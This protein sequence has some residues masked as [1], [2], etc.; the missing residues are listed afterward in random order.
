M[1][2]LRHVLGMAALFVTAFRFSGDAAGRFDQKLIIDKQIVHVLNRLTFGPRPGDVEQVRRMGVDKWI[3][4][5]LHPERITENPGLEAKVKP[6]ETTQLAMW[7]IMD[8]YAQPPAGF[9]VVPPSQKALNSLPQQQL[10]RLRNGSTEERV[11]TLALLDPDTRRLVLAAAGPPILEGLP[12]AVQ[13]EATK[14][15]QDEQAELQKERLRLMPPLNE[16]L[17]QDQVRTARQG[18]K[19][20]KAALLNSFDADKRQKVLRALGP[21]PFSDM[22]DL[23]REVMAA[24]QPQQLVNSELIE[25][26][27][28]R[29]VYSNRQLE[30]VLVDFWLNHFNVFNGKGQDRLYLTSF[31][32]DAIRPYVF[33]HFKDMLLATA[34]HPAML[35]YLDN[36]QSQ[37]MRDDQ[38]FQLPPG[39]QRP[40]LNENY[41]RELM[42]LHTLGV[43]GGYTQQD[44]IA[45]ARA[46]S[47]WS[48]YDIGKY[49]EF[50]F[51]PGSHD[52]KEKVVLGHTLPAGRGE[53]DGI[54]VIDILAHHPSTA[55]FISKELAQRFVADDPPQALVDRMAATFTKTDGDLRA[56]LQTM[57]TSVEFMSEGA[58]QAK[59]KS[60]LEMVVSSIRALN[61]DVTD[62]FALAQRIADLGEP[63]YGKVEP[64]GYPNTG[65]AWTNTSGVLGRINF[66]TALSSG[67]VQGVKAD[68]SRFNFKDPA[69]VAG[70]ILSA[71]PSPQTLTAIDKGI[72]DKEATPSLLTS[73]ILSSPDFQRR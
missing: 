25:N 27:L 36:W 4:Q 2:R 3:D 48:I 23:R 24:T 21:G 13:Q 66:A 57:F 40:G 55:K 62:T 32:R 50:Q 43:G 35:F 29:A 72:Q 26:R 18:A 52:R 14:A 63:L 6:L 8:K 58:W 38:Q 69:T 59:M 45:V 51:N 67:Q 30:E 5:Q 61:A 10:A 15:R 12:E 11:N 34:H 39:I 7:Q 64:T 53:Q 41:G 73:L 33:G 49:A 44:V 56:V 19:E 22:P 1:R 31:E 17:S 60:P 54:D 65:E 16:L 70:E 9:I 37:V 47:G 28:F 68:M 42:E 46:L 20:E 71:P